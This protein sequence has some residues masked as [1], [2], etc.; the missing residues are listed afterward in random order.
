[1]ARILV[2]MYIC[3]SYLMPEGQNIH[4]IPACKNIISNDQIGE[5][6]RTHPL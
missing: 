6:R 1:M 5:A 4:S 3:S 2:Y